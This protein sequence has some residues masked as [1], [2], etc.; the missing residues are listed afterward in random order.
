M[1]SLEQY[2]P[3]IEE[4]AKINTRLFKAGEVAKNILDKS[5]V[6]KTISK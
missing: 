3:A 2:R 6:P 5:Y 1:N 4:P